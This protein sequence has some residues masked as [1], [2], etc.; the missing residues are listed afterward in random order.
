MKDQ[1][2]ELALRDQNKTAENIPKDKIKNNIL[3]NSTNSKAISE[4]MAIV[5]EKDIKEVFERLKDR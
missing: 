4:I 3:D 2:Q 5:E 1:M